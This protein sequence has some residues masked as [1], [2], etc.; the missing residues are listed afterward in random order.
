MG[1]ADRTD[2]DLKQ[3]MEHSGVDLSYFD[4]VTNTKCIPY[5]IEPSFGLTRLFLA[6]MLDAYT[7]VP[8]DDTTTRTVLQLNPKLAP[9]KV[10]IMPLVKK[11][12]PQAQEVFDL[13]S[14]HMQCEYDEV[15]KVGRRY[16]RFDEIGTPWCVT[17]DSENY[18]PGQVSVRHRDTGEQEVIK[19]SELIS[20]F[21]E[22]LA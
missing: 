18:D 22:K 7:E 19:I 20:Y 5:V 17:I 15:G 14:P 8:L 11:L 10:G 9:I 16:Y 21:T 13:L 12:A 4:P 6:V 3:H 2:F 1:I